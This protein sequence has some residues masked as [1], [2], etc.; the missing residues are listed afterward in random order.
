MKKK[1]FHAAAIAAL[2]AILL[3]GCIKDPKGSDQPVAGIGK[4]V[5][6][7]TTIL[8]TRAYNNLWEQGDRIGVYMLPATA[9]ALAGTVR[10]QTGPLAENKLYTHETGGENESVVFAGIDEENTIRW[11]NGEGNVDF[12]AYY[13]WRPSG[14]ITDLVYP[15]DLSDQSVQQEIDLMYSSNVKGVSEGNPALRFEHKLTGLLF[16]VTDVDGT[17]LDGMTATIEG[18]PS[19]ARFDL[20]RG[21]IVAASEAGT[22]PFDAL[23]FSTSDGDPATGAD[24]D[25]TRE[26]AVVKA[27][28]L[29][30]DGLDYSVVFLLASG[31]RAVFGLKG[32][33]YEPGKRYIYDIVLSSKPGEEVGFGASGELSSITGWE[34]VKDGEQHDIVKDDDGSTDEPPSGDETGAAWSSGPL[35]ESPEGSMYSVSGNVREADGGGFELTKGNAVEITKSN[36]RGGVAS[37]TLY[38]KVSSLSSA[39]IRSVKVGDVAL[40]CEGQTEV[41][42]TKR[43]PEETPFTFTTMD[44]EPVSGDVVINLETSEGTVCITRFGI[45]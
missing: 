5:K 45:N 21:G 4:P 40:F 15:V 13:P 41:Q 37:V 17:S 24:D 42:L 36:Y 19:K 23:L 33:E 26:S 7:R 39:V 12:I 1:T 6:F 34:D 8:A 29:P 30:G 20:T 27:I 10:S 28:V 32:V 38:M 16:N 25:G 18:L 44:G 3:P 35:T 22:E 11:P 9:S 31:E 2:F 14:E 43:L